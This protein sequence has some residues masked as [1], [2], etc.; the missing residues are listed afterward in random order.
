MP[1]SSGDCIY[2]CQCGVKN[3]DGDDTQTPLVMCAYSLIYLHILFSAF[4]NESQMEHPTELC[5]YFRHNKCVYVFV[6]AKCAKSIYVY[7]CYWAESVLLHFIFARARSVCYFP[8]AA[9]R[10]AFIYYIIAWHQHFYLV[11]LAYLFDMNSN[12]ART[13]RSI[14]WIFPQFCR[15]P[16]Y[17]LSVNLFKAKI[18]SLMIL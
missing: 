3:D 5:Y 8:V 17:F 18:R 15:K 4:P 9:I 11:L 13:T 10:K 2:V 14:W 12:N 7:N 1:F 16:F 6:R